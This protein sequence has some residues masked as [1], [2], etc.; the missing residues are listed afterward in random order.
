MGLVAW[1]AHDLLLVKLGMV[2]ATIAA[3]LLAALFYAALLCALQVLTKQ[4]LQQ[5]PLVKKI[6]QKRKKA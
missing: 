6:V 1:W 2:L 5:L 4:E 3:M